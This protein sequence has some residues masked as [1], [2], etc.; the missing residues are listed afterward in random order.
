MKLLTSWQMQLE[1]RFSTWS[2]VDSLISRIDIDLWIYA[3]YVVQLAMNTSKCTLEQLGIRIGPR[4]SLLQHVLIL[5]SL[6]VSKM[7]ERKL[8]GGCKGNKDR[9]KDLCCIRGWHGP[10]GR[11][12]ERS[13]RSLWKADDIVPNAVAAREATIARSPTNGWNS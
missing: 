4:T 7:M 9:V 11:K 10:S 13:S 2:F 1:P 12:K 5:Y 6:A 8:C 3:T